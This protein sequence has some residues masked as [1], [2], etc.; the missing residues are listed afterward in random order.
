MIQTF[1]WLTPLLVSM[2]TGINR[3]MQLDP[4][5]QQW[6]KPLVGKSLRIRV[7][8]LPV[9]INF[10]FY[11][12]A[13]RLSKDIGETDAQITASPTTFLALAYVKEHKSFLTDGRLHIQGDL[14]LVQAFETL[15]QQLQPAWAEVVAPYLGDTLTH[16]V[17]EGVTATKQAAQDGCAH[18]K[19]QLTEY[20]QDELQLLP[21][22]PQLVDFYQRVDTLRQD[23]DRLAASISR[24][25][26]LVTKE[27][28]DE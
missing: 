4:A 6:L 25:N 23:T 13:V 9:V 28:H 3:Y 27:T 17:A 19:Q 26:T 2:E 21:A 22:K 24:L 15:W 5:W 1:D 14:A 18:L 7:R 11:E 10:Y 20:I 12:K 8:H 16:Y